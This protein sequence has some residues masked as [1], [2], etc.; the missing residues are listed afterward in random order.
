MIDQYAYG[1]YTVQRKNNAQVC[2][3]GI[4]ISLDVLEKS[5]NEEKGAKEEYT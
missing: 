3:L 4:R 5:I 1:I 2:L